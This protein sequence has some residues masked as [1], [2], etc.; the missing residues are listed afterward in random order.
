MILNFTKWN[1]I[2]RALAQG[3]RLYLNKYNTV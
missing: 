3:A 2:N 1:K